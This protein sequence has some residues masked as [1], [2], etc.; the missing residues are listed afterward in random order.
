VVNHV[1]VIRFAGFLDSHGEIV[2][3]P[4]GNGASKEDEEDSRDESNIRDG[5]S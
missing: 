3:C 1:G 5:L 2:E 4:E